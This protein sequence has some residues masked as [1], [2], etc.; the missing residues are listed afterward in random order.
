MRDKEKRERAREMEE[1]AREAELVEE[2]GIVS[3]SKKADE[4]L[5]TLESSA[6]ATAREA[7][8]LSRAGTMQALE[9]QPV[10]LTVVRE[11]LFVT[12]ES[13]R[14]IDEAWHLYRKTAEHIEGTLAAHQ[15][16][17]H[18]NSIRLGQSAREAKEERARWNARASEFQRQARDLEEVK[19]RVEH[20]V[21][22]VDQEL[23]ITVPTAD[24]SA[25]AGGGGGAGAATGAAVAV[26]EQ[27]ASLAAE[28][29]QLNALKQ[30]SAIVGKHA[31]S[32]EEQRITLKEVGAWML[33]DHTEGLTRKSLFVTEEMHIERI[34]QSMALEIESVSFSHE[35]LVR[36]LE[37][38]LKSAREMYVSPLEQERA[39]RQIE[40][41]L[42]DARAQAAEIEE[43]RRKLIKRQTDLVQ[44]NL[45]L[46]NQLETFKIR[47]SED[48]AI[49][50]REKG[51]FVA[52]I[53]SLRETI[54]SLTLRM[55]RM[56][57]GA[58]GPG[59]D[60]KGGSGDDYGYAATV[61]ARLR[62]RR[63]TKM[64]SAEEAALV[65]RET[66]AAGA[67]AITRTFEFSLD[68]DDTFGE[69]PAPP[70]ADER[71][72]RLVALTRFFR[73]SLEVVLDKEHSFLLPPVT[74]DPELR[75]FN[76]FNKLTA[77]SYHEK[78]RAE[79]RAQSK[80]WIER[81]EKLQNEAAE[82]RIH[83]FERHQAE[84]EFEL[85]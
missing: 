33:S 69:T 73:G 20:L 76:Q 27:G 22:K 21:D 78:M 7:A 38:M 12:P 9:T 11:N 58:G 52:E 79:V 14:A 23:T 68:P 77:E 36:V 72:E 2:T 46:E 24:G 17:Q 5:A 41:E 70:S 15:A 55:S 74:I 56:S 6:F 45:Y 19:T 63:G 81:L 13:R 65:F 64:L 85:E 66:N 31:A 39:L 80:Q 30:V 57:G 54:S 75:W 26:D 62:A 82:S 60:G 1:D 40:F 34:K 10:K 37:R 8:K 28:I 47:S 71:M 83:I 25:G 53:E 4:S 67:D 61:A 32:T 50:D 3:L 42:Q 51:A 49:M 29:I 59:G 16:V 48:K 18:Y 44:V 35:R 43:E 84:V